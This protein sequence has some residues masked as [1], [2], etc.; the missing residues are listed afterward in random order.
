MAA[1]D[2][3][4][5]GDD[6]VHYVS[7]AI[8][9]AQI[10]KTS[11]AYTIASVKLKLYKVG[12]PGEFTVSIQGVDGDG[13]PDDTDLCSGTYNG[14]SLG[15]A[16]GVFVEI[17]FTVPA[18]LSNATTYA[19]VVGLVNANAVYWRDEASS[20]YT[21]G[22]GAQWASGTGWVAKSWD[23]MFE[24]YGTASA[25][26]P[27]SEK[28][29]S[30][31]LVAASN[32]E[33]WHESSA[34]TMAELEAA[35]GNI[36]TTE[37]FS[38][39]EAYGKVFIANGSRF[40]VVDFINTVLDLGSGNE[41]TTPPGRGDLLTQ[42]GTSAKMLVD[43]V[44]SDKRYIYGYVISGT[45]NT[46]GDIT[47]T[48]QADSTLDAMDPNPIT[49]TLDDAT[50]PTTP[51]WYDWTVYPSIGSKSYGS[52]PDKASNICLYRGRI[53]L[54]RNTNYPFQWYLSKQGNPWDWLYTDTDARSAVAGGNSDVGEIGDIVIGQIPYKDDYL[55]Y[56]C[57]SS[58]WYLMGDPMM[59][60]A[61]IE[62]DLTQGLLAPLAFC[63]DNNGNL[64][65][66]TTAGFIRIPRGFGQIEN[67]TLI[68]YPDFINNLAYDPT[69]HRLTLAFDKDNHGILISK[70]VLLTGVNVNY[71]YDLRTEGLF[72]DVYPNDGGIF[73]SLDYKATDPDYRKL[74]FGCNDG[75]I[76]WFDPDSTDDDTVDSTQA[77]DSYVTFGPLPLT[78]DIKREGKL[79][80]LDF[81]TAGGAASG[82]QSDSNDIYFRVFTAKSAEEIIEKL[83]ADSDYRIAG[84]IIAPGRRR[85][86]GIKKKIRG[87]F[88]GVKLGNNT[89]SE[90]WAF[91][92][93]LYNITRAGR[94]K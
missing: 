32:N 60:G 78:D 90:T 65:M 49:A 51:H 36:D 37:P 91:E 10:F 48:T 44:D 59:G 2:Y 92:K 81:I 72:Y 9:A 70:T 67:L 30:V 54:T 85:G 41:M 33:V 12:T 25:T 42:T 4:N 86:S 35:T 74:L 46:T 47:Q 21:D 8:K 69:L 76:R 82:S 75:Y 66:V 94:L 80:D 31:K 17:T 38:M 89:A 5:T 45:F 20:D 43:F 53:G 34:G 29:H 14:N 87:V 61:L 40:K 50:A 79:V 58:L 11:A 62:L 55:V 15:G 16:D 28:T 52:M 6:D 19:I 56:G 77:I 63:W 3:W 64:Y 88:I 57:A 24:T 1:I 18:Q 27:S 39:I 73:S 83:Y 71:W 13:L 93:M 68:D 84:T 22:N 7:T 23:S 26:P